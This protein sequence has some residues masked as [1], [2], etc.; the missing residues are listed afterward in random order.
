MK[1]ISQVSH[2]GKYFFF[3]VAE[4]DVDIKS[5]DIKKKFNKVKK[6]IFRLNVLVKRMY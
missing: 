4:V 5:L 1:S 3:M 2:P 6:L